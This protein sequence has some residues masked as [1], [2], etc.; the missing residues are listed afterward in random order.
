MPLS[1]RSIAISVAS[2]VI[3]LVYVCS[4]IDLV[5]EALIPVVG[6]V[7]DLLVLVGGMV[8]ARALFVAALSERDR[9]R[10]ALRECDETEP[11][12]GKWSP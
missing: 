12:Y 7:D 5:P 11:L 10:N 8:L 3:A 2:T 4:P 1:R 6:F 9:R